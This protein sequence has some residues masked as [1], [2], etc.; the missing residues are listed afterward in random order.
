MSTIGYHRTVDGVLTS[1]DSATLTIENSAGT[2]IVNEV[3]V[4]PSS[5]GVYVYDVTAF[6]PGRYTATW[7]FVVAGF[8]NDVVAVSFQIEGSVSGM[9]GVRLM[10]I[11]QGIARRVGPYAKFRAA[12][13]ATQSSVLIR[14][15]LSNLDQGDWEGMYLLRR[16]LYA[17]GSL[18]DNFNDDD[19]IRIV[20]TYTSAIGSL[21]PDYDWNIAPAENEEIELHTLDPEQELRPAATNGLS[22]CYFYDTIQVATTTY[23]RD[24]DLTDIAPWITRPEQIRR[25]THGRYNYLD[26]KAPFFHARQIGST[27]WLQTAIPN[28]GTMDILALRPHSSYVNDEM[29]FSGPD[30]DLDILHVDLRYAVIAGHMSCWEEHAPRLQRAAARNYTATRE[31]VANEFTTR[32][33]AIVKQYPDVIQ[34][35]FGQADLWDNLQIGNA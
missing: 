13:G 21:T 30:H 18:V 24:L 8:A 16:G 14:R 5:A 19:R 2:I 12:P 11:E 17:D 6:Q 23:L 4:V 35:Q 20:S 9:R 33:Q 3:A 29:S 26:M 31:D 10:T 22:R 15:L 25:V 7:T 32:S 1:A 28:L 34:N 27:I